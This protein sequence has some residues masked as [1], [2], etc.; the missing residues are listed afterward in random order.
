[1]RAS[2]ILLILNI[3]EIYGKIIAMDNKLLPNNQK[4]RE[5]LAKYG[6]D[7]LTDS[8]LLELII[9]SG[10]DGRSAAVIAQEIINEVNGNLF[11]FA[12]YSPLQFERK[13][14]SKA[15]SSSLC[16]AVELGKRIATR[17]VSDRIDVNHPEKVK[18][19]FEAEIRSL[20]QENFLVLMINSKMEVIRKLTVSIGSSSSAYSS[21][22]D[23]FAAAIKAG[24]AAIIV[25]HNHPSGDPSPSAADITVTKKLS[26]AGK[27][28]DVP[29]LDHIII[30]LKG[31]FSFKEENML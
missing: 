9:S 12:N 1:M 22:R 7:H 23:V 26:D 6:A 28:M 21:P 15:K 31:Y 14:I 25:A 20:P 3:M 29:L 2:F 17:E 4:P 13:G 8:E 10:T 27:I 5:R 24:A 11:E 16:A 18:K 30:G 19:V